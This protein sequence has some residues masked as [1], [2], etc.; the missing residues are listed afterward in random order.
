MGFFSHCVGI[1]FFFQAE[2]GIR[3]ADV[4]GVQT[5]ALPIFRGDVSTLVGQARYDL[6]WRQARELRRVADG[7][8]LV[9]L[10]LAQLVTRDGPRGI[11][12]TIL[13]D[14]ASRILPALQ[15]AWA[16]AKSGAG[17]G[18]AGS[19]CCCLGDEGHNMS[20]ILSRRHSSAPPSG[21]QIASA[22]FRRIISAAA[23]ASAFSLRS[24]SRSSCCT[25]LLASRVSRAIWRDAARSQSLA[26]AQASRQTASCSA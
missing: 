14:P 8:D 9:A 22:F 2:D 17:G 1:C 23:S 25:R 26:R 21:P 18:E 19:G 3:D 5:C 15:R 12:A 7:D 16:Q 6:T 4:T 20:A 24:S 10:H 11:R 13:A